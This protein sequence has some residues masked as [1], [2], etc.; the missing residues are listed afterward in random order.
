MDEHTFSAGAP[1]KLQRVSANLTIHKGAAMDDPFAARQDDMW[2]RLKPVRAL[3][4]DL[5]CVKI[6]LPS[7]SERQ[8]GCLVGMSIFEPRRLFGFN[9][10]LTAICGVKDVAQ[11]SILNDRGATDGRPDLPGW[12]TDEIFDDA[13]PWS[14]EYQGYSI[15][16]WRW[17]RGVKVAFDT[18]NSTDL[19]RNAEATASALQHIVETIRPS[20]TTMTLSRSFPEELTGESAGKV[21]TRLIIEP[22]RKWIMSTLGVFGLL[23][24]IAMVTG[25]TL[26]FSLL[27]P[28]IAT[29]F[30]ICSCPPQWIPGLL[31]PEARVGLVVRTLITLPLALLVALSWYGYFLGPD[32]YDLKPKQFSS[33]PTQRLTQPPLVPVRDDIVGL[34]DPCGG[35]FFPKGCNSDLICQPKNSAWP[36]GYG[37]PGTCQ[38]F[39]APD[40]ATPP[41]NTTTLQK[42]Q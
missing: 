34:G 41:D 36:H 15:Q 20:L 30:F 7:T 3:L 1:A 10:V 23:V 13:H 8:E 29:M 33:T 37:T 35:D 16:V 11:I 42:T 32:Q 40:D 38:P 14:P 18:G 5:H 21:F 39:K 22:N 31:P 2:V 17:F 9:L 28:I 6:E 12:R 27:V 26:P 25:K 4:A 24:P 19:E